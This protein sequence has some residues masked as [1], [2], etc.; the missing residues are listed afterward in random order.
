MNYKAANANPPI[1]KVPPM[2]H[3]AEIIT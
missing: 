1:G 3:R 2:E